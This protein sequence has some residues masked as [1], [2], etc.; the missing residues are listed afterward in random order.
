MQGIL[1]V[2]VEFLDGRQPEEQEIPADITPGKEAQACM[3]LLAGITAIGGVMIF[4]KTSVE[5]TPISTIK[6]LTITAP[7]VV[8]A[9]GGLVTP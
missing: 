4:D 5:L 3:Q 6:K 9:G 1:K 2:Y 8:L 7:S